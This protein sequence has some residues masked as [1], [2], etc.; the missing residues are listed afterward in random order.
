ML[1][2]EGTCLF[3]LGELLLS[4]EAISFY[5]LLGEDSTGY[6]FGFFTGVNIIS[7]SRVLV[8]AEKSFSGQSE[9]FR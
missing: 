1:S 6:V 3:Q 8:G 7:S 2:Q 4:V 9:D 5:E